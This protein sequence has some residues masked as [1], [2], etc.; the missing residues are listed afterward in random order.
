MKVKAVMGVLMKVVE[1][2][3]TTNYIV[4]GFGCSMVLAKGDYGTWFSLSHGIGFL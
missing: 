4:H 2:L 1:K 3:W